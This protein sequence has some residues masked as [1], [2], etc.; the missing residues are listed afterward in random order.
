MRDLSPLLRPRSIA[1]IGAS[2]DPRRGNGRT[3][4]YLIEGGY[5]GP[6]YPVNPNRSEVQ[7]LRA[8]TR[9]EDVPGPVDAAIVAVP[10]AAAVQAVQACA[11]A[12][13]RSAIVYAAGFAEAGEG[14]RELQARLVEAARRTGMPVLGPNSLGAFD[15]RSRSF[16][17]F[18]SMFDDGYPEVG[19]IGMVTQSGGYGSQVYKLAADRGVPLV[20][21]VS[22]GNE[23]DIGAAELLQAMAHDPGIDVLLAYFEGVRDGPALLAALR[24]A[25]RRGKVVIVVKAGRTEAGGRAAATHT[26]TLA[27]EDRVYDEVFR[28]LG[29]HRADSVEE[30][31]DVACVAVR[32]RR[33]RGRRLVLLSPSGGFAVQM[34]DHAVQH[35]L[36]LPIVAPALQERIRALV[37]NAMPAN[38][39]DLTGQILNELPRFG[40]VLDLLLEGDAYDAAGLFVGMA[41]GAPTLADAWADALEA[42]AS[43]HPDKALLLSIVAPPAQVRRY[44]AAGYAVFEDTFRMLRAHGALVRMAA[45]PSAGPA[46]LP[47]PDPAWAML[48]PHRCRHEADAKR[49]LNHLGIPALVDAVCAD[50]EAAVQAARRCGY[51]VAV[52]VLSADLPHKTEVG[53]VVLDV[54]DEAAVRAAVSAIGA[55]VAAARPDARI[56]GYLVAP[57][58]G[59]GIECL[60]GVRHDPTFGPVVVFGAGGVLAELLGDRALRLAPVDEAGALAMIDETRIARLLHGWRN[61]P[62]ADV[63][64]LAG[65]IARL[66]RYSMTPA[67]A[68]CGIEI[69]PLLVRPAGRGVI[70]LDALVAPG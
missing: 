57:M 35:G 48:D 28:S 3:L 54:P 41:G 25:R 69:N 40:E 13:V 62:P 2:S 30:M 38:P 47:V 34:T 18:S 10:A 56:E 65:A 42:A 36:E 11:E 7:G 29:V 50:A 31:L 55:R 16:M 66:S 19:R 60:L 37:P 53:G 33:P 61:Q 15:A 64:A 22:C 24:E 49:L 44:E 51:P 21:W 27:G 14:G 26:A 9:I 6:V 43:R 20:Q 67:A 32:G 68:G 4:R 46:P 1:M 52:K 45:A 8:Y 70:A 17:T 23:C 59:E 58:A 5:A 63:P 39:V 12:G